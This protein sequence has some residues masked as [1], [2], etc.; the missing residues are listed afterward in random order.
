M[1]NSHEILKN[2]H[3]YNIFFEMRKCLGCDI[4]E[5]SDKGQFSKHTLYLTKLLLLCVYLISL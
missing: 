4:R 1:V 3:S 5:Q 2:N